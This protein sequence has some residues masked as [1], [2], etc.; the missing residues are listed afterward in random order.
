MIMELLGLDIEALMKLCGSKFSLKT[1][2]AIAKQMVIF[3]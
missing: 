3:Y 1:T 2:V